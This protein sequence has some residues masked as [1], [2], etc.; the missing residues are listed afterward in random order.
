MMVAFKVMLRLSLFVLCLSACRG[1]ISQMPDALSSTQI[2]ALLPDAFKMRD[3]YLLPYREVWPE[4]PKAL[5]LALHGFNDYSHAF[6]GMCDYLS[7]RSVACIAYDQRGFGATSGQGVWPGDGVLQSDLVQVIG[8]LKEN[9]PDVPLY[10]LG[11]SMGGAVIMSGNVRVPEF[12]SSHIEGAILLAPA[13]WARHTQPWY[14]RW[15]LWLAVHTVP[16]WR[17]TGEGLEIQA[18]DN[19]EALREMFK[20]PLV[21]KATRIDAIYGLNNLMD[22]ALM[23]SSNMPE[24]TLVLYGEKDEVIPKRPTC[25]ML[26]DLDFEAQGVSFRLYPEGYHMLSRDL[27]AARVFSDI[28]EWMVDTSTFRK[29][30]QS[31]RIALCQS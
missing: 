11:E 26:K 30:S 1:P 10:V 19:I 23:A 9:W 8:L 20:D 7:A 4:N 16:S 13:V 25:E 21:I 6:S 12:F 24:N 29:Q 17:P 2:P 15:L 31:D 28:L 18:T 27:Q 14:Q 22:E 3:G 5:V